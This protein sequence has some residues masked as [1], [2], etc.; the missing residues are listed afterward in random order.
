MKK[1]GILNSDISKVLSDMGHKDFICIGDC[2]L[3]VPQGVKKIDLALKFGE[4]SFI[5][6]LKEVYNDMH[7]EKIILAKEIKTKNKEQLKAIEQLFGK[8][9]IEFV[10]HE[11]FKKKTCYAKAII[12][13]G[14]ITPFSN[15]I[16][17]SNVCF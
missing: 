8:I 11:D 17:I 16:L 1:N 14:E 6:T 15:I 10:S 13:T 2:G 9:D 12:R 3:P 7:V 4:P 5:D